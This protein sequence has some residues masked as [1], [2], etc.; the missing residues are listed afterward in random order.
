MF[1][2]NCQENLYNFF[3]LFYLQELPKQ[4]RLSHLVLFLPAEKSCGESAVPFCFI[5]FEIVH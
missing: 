2:I 1:F 4:I 5:S 3:T